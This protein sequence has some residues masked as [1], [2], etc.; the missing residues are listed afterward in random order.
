MGQTR[1]IAA[2][3]AATDALWASLSADAHEFQ[4]NPQRAFPDF[5]SHGE[6]R[7]PLN[8][9]ARATLSPA[10][11]VRYGDHPLRTLDIFRAEGRAPVHLFLH[12]GYWRAQD[13]RNFAFVAGALVPLGI[14]TIVAN[15]ELCPAST[16]DGVVDSALAAFEWI[17]RN[18]DVHG[19]DPARLTIS[20]HSAGAHLAAEILATD[21]AARGVDT[22]GLSGVT[23][24]S[25]IYDPAPAIRTSVNAQLQLD[26]ALAARHDVER[27]APQLDC[28]VSIIVGG[29]E[30]WHWI[31][32]SFRYSHHLRRHGQDPS[33][34]V[35]PG[36]DHFGILDDYLDAESTTMKA[37]VA[38]ARRQAGGRFH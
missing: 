3:P 25:G 5:A 12:G 1:T 19:G 18:P 32:Q 7:A 8:D 29:R 6:R 28:P 14:T 33:V 30:P 20:G 34:H 13:K 27:R 22:S 9:A 17:V 2:A 15:Y 35:L 37:I 21:W 38:G 31:D 10:A 24:I 36:H 11:D 23:L 26:A 16:L 4:Y